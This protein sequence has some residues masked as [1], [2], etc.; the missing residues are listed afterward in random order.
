M[1]T[2][3]SLIALFFLV[4]CD[5]TK[6][7]WGKYRG[8]ESQV[9]LPTLRYQNNNTIKFEPLTPHDLLPDPF[10]ANE[11]SALL[12]K[13]N[14]AGNVNYIKDFVLYQAWDY[15]HPNVSPAFA[16]KEEALEYAD[17]NN[18]SDGIP[19]G[20]KYVVRE[21]DHRY[22]VRVGF[23]DYTYSNGT[24]NDVIYTSYTLNE[25]KKYLNTYRANTTEA[26]RYSTIIF[27][28]M[29]VAVVEVS[30]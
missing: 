7:D 23:S 3:T 16:T 27:D 6:P 2:L 22:E 24:W 21:I 18:I 13:M 8:D 11:V 14:E 20:H 1:K 10:L 12:V 5:T 9:E 28:L 30:L 25:A 19:T 4:G 26:S 15:L 17:G 29:K